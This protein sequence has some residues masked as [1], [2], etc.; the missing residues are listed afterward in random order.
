MVERNLSW[1]RKFSEQFGISVQKSPP[2]QSFESHCGLLS[3]II[4]RYFG[5]AVPF[6]R[7]EPHNVPAVFAQQYASIVFWMALH[8]EEQAS[9]LLEEHVSAGTFGSG[10]DT[11]AARNERRLRKVVAS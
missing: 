11:I 2:A 1:S 7:K 4:F 3:E 5:V 8:K 6:T 10:Q 9:P